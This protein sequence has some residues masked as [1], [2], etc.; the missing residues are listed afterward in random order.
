MKWYKAWKGKM[1]KTT[2]LGMVRD[3]QKKNGGVIKERHW[4]E[5]KE[6]DDES[7]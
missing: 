4:E 5:I 2:S 6:E 7:N 3:Y 1:F